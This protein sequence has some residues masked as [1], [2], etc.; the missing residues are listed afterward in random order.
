MDAQR[1][2]KIILLNLFVVGVFLSSCMALKSLDGSPEEAI[3]EFQEETTRQDAYSGL[4]TQK[5]ELSKNVVLQELEQ[6]LEEEKQKIKE[7]QETE[8]G[9]EERELAE[10]QVEEVETAQE[11]EQIAKTEPT[12]IEEEI[13]EAKSAPP[14]IEETKT[15]SLRIKVLSGDGDMGSARTM[16]K[17]LKEMGYM[18]ERVD[19]APSAG[20]VNT[21]V[22]YQSAFRED[23]KRLA[24]RIGSGTTRKPLTWASQFNIIVVTGNQP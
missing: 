6:R 2:R 11:P 13:K 14:K 5:V 24:E 8:E 23:A 4:E 18:V 12:L 19:L 22:F 3:V 7:E 20:F 15:V 17:R 10:E 9:V 16:S 1:V 21:T